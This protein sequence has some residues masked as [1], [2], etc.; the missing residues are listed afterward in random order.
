[1][2]MC[3]CFLG[4]DTAGFPISFF[5]CVCERSNTIQCL[6]QA[7]RALLIPRPGARRLD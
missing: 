5:V 2:C 6:S 4:R 1:M 3:V 7:V